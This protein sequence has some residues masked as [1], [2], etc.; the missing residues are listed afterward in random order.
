MEWISVGLPHYLVVS[1]ILFSC[2]VFCVLG[3]RNAVAILMGVELILNSANLNLV[4]FNYFLHS[5]R[6]VEGQSTL[7]LSGH[8][9][10][11]FVIVL[12]ACEA[13]VFLAILMSLYQRI[14]KIDV[15]EIQILK[16]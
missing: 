14:E 6:V 9:L 5:H 4:A 13:A 12:A 7:D 10:A 16:G 2:G 15:D 3:R 11:I 8:M 1:A